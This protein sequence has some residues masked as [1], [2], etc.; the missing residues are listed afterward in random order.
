M[1]G[2]VDDTVMED[3][4]AH[5]VEGSEA[6]GE[7]GEEVAPRVKIVRFP[8]LLGRRGGRSPPDLLCL[9]V[10]ANTQFAPHSYP[11]PWTLRRRLSF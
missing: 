7:D 11:G 8:P 4:P 9:G 3:V 6:L 1:P 2:A 5:Q 10:V